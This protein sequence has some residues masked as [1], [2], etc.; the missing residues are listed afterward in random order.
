MNNELMPLDNDRIVC[1]KVGKIRRENL[2]EM[3]RKYWKVRLEKASQATHVL[4]I[5]DGIVEAVY[6]PQKWFHSKDFGKEHRLEFV[7]KEDIYSNYIGKSVKN[8]YGQSK[9]PIKYINFQDELIYNKKNKKNY[10]LISS[11]DSIFNLE[12]CLSENNYV[13][14]QGS[15]APK[16]GDIVF[17]YRTKPSQRICYIM[18]VID[19]NIPYHNTINDTK[20]WREKHAPNQEKLYH[21][22]ELLEDITSLCLSLSKLQEHGMKGV[23]QGPRKLSGHLL[24]F[25]LSVRESEQ[26]FY[27]EIEN[28]EDIYE[29]A[30]KTIVINSYERNREARYACIAAHGCKCSVCEM[31]FE[32]KYGELGRGFI[33]VHHIVPISTIGKEYR[34]DP[35]KDL[36]PVCPNCHA[37][38][39]KGKAGEI[40]TIDELKEI[41]NKNKT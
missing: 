37:M 29:G 34:I 23:P 24:Q 13:D 36:V 9:N 40:L 20:Y 30:K 33:H 21:R 31:D 7:G 32:K 27:D 19:I 39:H 3:T 16:L 18:K 35:E 14:W 15:F 22:L 8:Y 12:E 6:I 26:D 5:I 1:V 38:L 17:I 2:Y 41:I 10:W 25:I 28:P 11:N 4:A